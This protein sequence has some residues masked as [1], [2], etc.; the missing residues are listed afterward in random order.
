MYLRTKV[1]AILVLLAIVAKAGANPPD[2]APAKVQIDA[3]PQ[4]VVQV[5][6][7]REIRALVSNEIYQRVSAERA[8]LE[9]QNERQFQAVENL[10]DRAIYFT[11]ALIAAAS[12]LLGYFVGQ[13]FKEAQRKFQETFQATLE[14]KA[15]AII[16]GEA[17]LLRA[18]YQSLKGE[19][20][21]LTE[22]RTKDIAWVLPTGA[23]DISRI[24]DALVHAGL[25][26]PAI[27]TPQESVPVEIGDPDLVV[28]SYDGSVE[29]FRV[30]QEVIAT[31]NGREPPVSLLVYTF[32]GAAGQVRLGGREFDALA[33]FDWFVPVN[34]PAQ[35]LAQIQ[36]LIRQSRVV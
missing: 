24:L 23:S 13:S 19:V 7:E 25:K 1:S 35:L 4:T 9:R 15:Q 36:M 32:T 17:D 26:S 28:L 6:S 3:N 34:F 10:I 16:D 8:I 33:G 20:D 31:I 30:L 22:Y 29:A 2:E 21:A 14:Q 27:L 18:R 11:G 12:L 5:Q